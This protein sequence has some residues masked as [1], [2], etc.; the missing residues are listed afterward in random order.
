MCLAKPHLHNGIEGNFLS[1][2]EGESRAWGDL[3]GLEAGQPRVITILN[4]ADGVKT[5]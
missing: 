3:E 5:G 2:T 1:V 4:D